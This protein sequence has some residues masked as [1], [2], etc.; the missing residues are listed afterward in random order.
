[1]AY[2]DTEGTGAPDQLPGLADTLVAAA[3]VLSSQLIYAV[4]DAPTSGDFE[5]VGVMVDI[6]K[7]VKA[8]GRG[9]A[10][11]P[12]FVLLET[13][14]K[15]SSNKNASERL[16][17]WLR[18][19][20]DEDGKNAVRAAIARVLPRRHA[21][22]LPLPIDNVSALQNL[23]RLWLGWLRIKPAFH[24]ALSQLRTLLLGPEGDAAGPKMA[25]GAVVDGIMFAEMVEGLVASM[26]DGRTLPQLLDPLTS[27]AYRRARAASTAAVAACNKGAVE[28]AGGLAADS[29]AADAPGNVARLG[30]LQEAAAAD[31][32]KHTEG[33]LLTHVRDEI[34][35]ATRD[36]CARAFEAAL[37][38]A[39]TRAT[40]SG[41]QAA[42]EAKDSAIEEQKKAIE[43]QKNAIE[44]QKKAIA[45]LQAELEQSKVSDSYFI[46]KMHVLASHTY[47]DLGPVFTFVSRPL[48]KPICYKEY[49]GW[50]I[51]M[52]YSGYRFCAAPVQEFWKCN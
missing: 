1:M 40:I 49:C 43:E 2:L 39:R 15:L 35:G 31:Y 45:D 24:A 22:T 13:G 50:W 6:A 11:A 41:Q 38:G 8:T 18:P 30:A 14:V 47:D 4:L 23:P 12:A 29:L 25:A 28:H 7:S 26:N 48:Q 51:T 21:A 34:R 42:I 32:D 33:M 16:E 9:A 17:N 52:P 10:D 37:E 3:Y 44:E 46:K 19:T 20:G 5:G 27:L 36:G